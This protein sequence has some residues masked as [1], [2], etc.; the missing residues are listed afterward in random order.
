MNRNEKM[1]IR[2][3]GEQMKNK[4]MMLL[5]FSIAMVM[6]CVGVGYATEFSASTDN[7]NNSFS[8]TYMVLKL[9]E[10]A[11]ETSYTFT[12]NGPAYY[13]DTSVTSA[14]SSS[15]YKS[16]TMVSD[17]V[18]MFIDGTEANPIATS[19]TV[20]LTSTVSN[21]DLTIQFYDDAEC[22]LPH[23]NRG[24]FTLTTTDQSVG[25]FNT[26]TNYF[27]KVTVTMKTTAIDAAPSGNVSFGL[28]F[29]STVNTD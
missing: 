14:G 25:S 27:C 16:Y 21:A 26:D 17:R 28:T 9:N 6:V 29:I 19:L 4:G 13:R 11:G 8:S 18:W 2:F 15:V 3:R 7:S 10:G 22:T 23:E 1:K 12:F 5:A 24:P 20:S